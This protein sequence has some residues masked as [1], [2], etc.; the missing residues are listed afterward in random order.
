MTRLLFHVQH[1]VGIGHLRRAERLAR[2]A[3]EAGMEVHVA[4]GGAATAGEDW[5]RSVV[6]ALPALHADPNDFGRLLTEAGAAPDEA[7]KARRRADLLALFHRLAPDVL[8]LEG[9][10]F[11]RRALRFELEPLLAAVADARL[12]PAVAVSLRDI[13]VAKDD[14]ART[15]G[16]IDRVRASVDQVLVH[17]DPQV[18]ALEASFPAAASI[19]DKIRYTGYVGPAA[20]VTMRARSG[21]VASVGGGAVGMALLIAAAAA[22]P[23]TRLAQSPWSLVTGPAMPEADA[24]RIEALAGPGISVFRNRPDLPVMMAEATLSISQAG[25]NTVLDLLSAGPRAVLVPF[26]APGETEQTQRCALLEAA[27]VA[28]VT[29][30]RDLTPERLAAAIEHALD[31]PAPAFTVAM[32]G[33]A[34]TAKLLQTLAA[35]DLT[36]KGVAR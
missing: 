15:Q 26:A 13:L 30:E 4:R 25:Y 36:V 14:P 34:E 27:G 9:Y 1:L 24:R 18:I 11:A 28:V 32:D 3:A 12:R 7:F 35:K 16:I 17:G 23:L 6:H 21:V 20:P 33:A 5:G 2:A 31:R 10:P 22:R 8:L 19:A 29:P